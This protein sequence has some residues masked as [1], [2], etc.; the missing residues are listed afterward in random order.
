MYGFTLVTYRSISGRKWGLEL[1]FSNFQRSYEIHFLG[2]YKVNRARG[3]G[4]K[5]ATQCYFEALKYPILV[6]KT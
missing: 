1:L 2:T 6:V 5:K 3:F 4:L